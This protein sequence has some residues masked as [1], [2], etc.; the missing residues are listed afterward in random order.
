[1]KEG[2]VSCVCVAE[3]FWTG[4]NCTRCPTKGMDCSKAGATLKDLPLEEGYW[5]SD[6]A[7]STIMQCPVAKACVSAQSMKLAQVK[8]EEIAT[9]EGKLHLAGIKQTS[10]VDENDQIKAS[11][12][13]ELAEHGHAPPHHVAS[14]LRRI[15]R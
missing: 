6:S 15:R 12:Y 7:T 10:L 9:I 2:S 4:N 1:M 14:R 3:Y 11:F 13:L 5:R 8:K